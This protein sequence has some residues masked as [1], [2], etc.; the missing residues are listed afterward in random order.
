MIELIT[1]HVTDA[2]DRLIEQYRGATTLEAFLES[3]VNEIQ[4]GEN[5]AFDLR[6]RLAIFEVGGKQ[7]DN[8]GK[9]VVQTRQ[10]L[11][12]DLY[13]LF[14]LAKIG[15]NISNGEHERLIAIF[16]LLTQGD[17]VYLMYH[18]PGEIALST[19]GELPEEYT[20]FVF[21][22]LEK[23]AAGGVKIIDLIFTPDLPFAFDGPNLSAPSAGFGTIA[24][25]SV[26]GELSVLR[27]RS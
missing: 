11:E 23:A 25:L 18:G 12:D 10:G 15:V 16:R 24:D 4:N 2:K 17:V 1:T 9:I 8:F 19:N 27:R 26:G 5:A 20:D 21:T 6:E 22:Q 13:R 14:L 3:I 7:L